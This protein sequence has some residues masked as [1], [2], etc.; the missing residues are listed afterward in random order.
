MLTTRGSDRIRGQG[1]RSV[2]KEGW[3]GRERERERERE[4][5]RERECIEESAERNTRAIG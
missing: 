2:R 5:E 3:T 1:T 4:I